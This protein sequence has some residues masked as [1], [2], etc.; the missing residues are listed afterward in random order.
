MLNVIELY[1]S[2]NHIKEK[3]HDVLIVQENSVNSFKKPKLKMTYEIYN[4]TERFT[5]ELFVDGK[6]E[7][8]FSKMDLGEGDWNSPVSYISDAKD[9]LKRAKDLQKKGIEFYQMLIK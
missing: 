4:S 7:H 3:S 6:W 1:R 5:G 9:R 8:C 2:S